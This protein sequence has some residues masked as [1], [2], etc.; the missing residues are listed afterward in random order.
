MKSC[1]MEKISMKRNMLSHVYFCIVAI[2]GIKKRAFPFTASPIFWFLPGTVV[3]AFGLHYRFKRLP[4]MVFISKPYG[5]HI[6]NVRFPY[7]ERTV[8]ISRT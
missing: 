7:G 6:K 1:D 8:L 2:H 3:S 5:F 4:F